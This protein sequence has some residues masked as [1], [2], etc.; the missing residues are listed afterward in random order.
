MP[1]RQ[2]RAAG[3]VGTARAVFGGRPHLGE[4]A[5]ATASCALLAAVTTYRWAALNDAEYPGHADRAFYFGVAQNLQAGR[6]PVIDY[7]WEFLSG[8][9]PLPQYAFGY[10]LPLPSYLMSSV[11]TGGPHDLA[12]ALRVNLAMG[13]LTWLGTYLLAR[14]LSSQRWLPGVAAAIVIVLPAFSDYSVAAEAALYLSAFA[15]L[16]MATALG[17]RRRLW[18]WPVAGMFAGLANASRNEGLLVFVV[19]LCAAVMWPAAGRRLGAAVAYVAGYLLTMGPEMIAA[20]RHFGTVLPPASASFP[21]ISDPEQIFA[22]H[23][24]R[25]PAALFAGGPWQFVYI[26]LTSLDD[27]VSAMLSDLG[28]LESALLLLAIGAA[29]ARQKFRVRASAWREAVASS[30]FV[31]IGFCAATVALQAFVAPA[32]SDSGAAQKSGATVMIVVVV[33]GLTAL[34]RIGMRPVFTI[35]VV[36]TLVLLPLLTV[37]T[38]TRLTVDVD[39]AYGRVARGLEPFFADEQRCLGRPVVLMTRSPWEFNQATGMAAVQIPDDPLPVILDIA[40]RYG[41]T[42]IRMDADR[43]A[44]RDLKTLTGPDGLLV[45]T[46]VKSPG[47]YRIR[48]ATLQATC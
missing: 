36:V 39:N 34:A 43:P 35:S 45:P 13:V 24:H 42:H 27:T 46:R 2:R 40:K 18:L 14:Q 25:T 47:V 26:R 22:A 20:H 5:V 4:A 38:R 16:A 32:V 3:L 21:F 12:A 33:A 6:G 31:P 8:M 48:S 9:H 29:L 28:V 17:A 30:W 15:V 10:W 23:V 7:A 41:V 37:P 1:N 19:I 44:L 11:M